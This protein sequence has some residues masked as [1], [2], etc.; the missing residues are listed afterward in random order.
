MWEFT[1]EPEFQAKLDW[2]SDFM[3]SEIEPLDLCYPDQA[4]RPLSDELRAVVEPLKQQVR[5][6]GLWA[7]H[8]GPELGGQGYGAV[9]LVLL[10]EI[11]GRSQ[12][13]H[14]LGWGPIIFG[15]QAPDT[16]NAEILAHYGT[17]EQKQRYLEPLLA[18]EI[19]SAFSMTEPQGG[20]DPGSFETTARQEGD[21][22]VITGEKWFTSN[23]RYAS[24][25]IVMAV[26]DPAASTGQRTSMFLVPAGTPGLTTIR[27]AASAAHQDA[28]GTHAYLR[29]DDVRVPL[30][31]LLG[32]VGQGFTVA[33]TRLAGGRLHHAMRTVAQC[34]RALDM[35]CERALSRTSHGSLLADKQ[36][37]QEA[38]ALSYM[39]LEQ[40]RLF[41]LRA[42]S[43]CDRQGTYA[44]RKDIAAAK[45]LAA[46]VVTDIVGRAI[47]IHGSLGMSNEL[48]LSLMWLQAPWMGV[49]D[50]PTE[51]HVATVSKLLL[52]DYSAAPGLWPSEHLPTKRAKA[53]ARFGRCDP[54]LEQHD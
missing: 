54:R 31:H 6:R 13:E 29:Y 10:N 18:G 23:A 24:F 15:T 51:L 43:V 46:R 35:M 34:R 30:D 32:E 20:S 36:L 26:T 16:G 38:I 44:A 33:Q 12:G 5:D 41:V 1:T 9:K 45:V 27:N 48:P 37:V 22:W 28:S 19:F 49:M 2:V 53:M 47:H 21:E 7:A 39:E 52:R 3:H 8:L 11:L 50:G 42:A 17:E 4:F 14:N 40:F 25:L